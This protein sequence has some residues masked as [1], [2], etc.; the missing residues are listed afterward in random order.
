MTT[1]FK[2]P[3]DFGEGLI[4]VLDSPSLDRSLIPTS[5][6]YS[7]GLYFH[8]IFRIKLYLL[9]SDEYG[10]REYNFIFT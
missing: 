6:F 1:K 7:L 2:Y 10:R 8:D 9:M 3:T 4:P 5:T